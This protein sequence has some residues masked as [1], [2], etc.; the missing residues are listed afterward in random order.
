V[1]ITPRGPPQVVLIT[2]GFRLL[3]NDALK[4]AYLD[5]HSLIYIQN[6][7]FSNIATRLT[8]SK[9]SFGLRQAAALISKKQAF[10]LAI[11]LSAWITGCA[12]FDCP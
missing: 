2:V 8:P 1:A 11:K 9:R 10:M 5:A 4:F 12:F 7:F 3:V 6:G